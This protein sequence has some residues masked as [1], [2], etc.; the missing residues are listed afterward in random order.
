MPPIHPARPGRIVA[1]ILL[2]VSAGRAPARAREA[3]P[4]ALS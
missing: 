4:K 2:V 3:R 1:L